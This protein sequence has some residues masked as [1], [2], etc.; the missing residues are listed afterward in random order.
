MNKNP[1]A[2][3]RIVK[4]FAL[5]ECRLLAESNRTFEDIYKI[6]FRN[7]QMVMAETSRGGEIL[8]C[9]YDDASEKIDRLAR[10]I[11][12]ATGETGRFVGISVKNCI[13]WIIIFWAILKSGNKPFLV[14][15]M[16]PV[17]ASN[18]VLTTLSADYVIYL[19]GNV[20]DYGKKPLLYSELLK[21]GESNIGDG[22]VPSFANEIAITTSGTSLNEKICIYSGAEITEQILNSK[23]AIGRDSDIARSCNGKIKIFAVLPLFHIFGLEATYLWLAFFRAVLV[24]PENMNPDTLLSTVRKHGIT[25]IFAVPL[26]WHTIEKTVMRELSKQDQKTQNEFEKGVKLSLAVQNIAPHLGKKLASKLFKDIRA[27][28]FGDS[29]RFCISGGSYIKESAL[30]LMNALGYSLINGYGMSEIG[31]AAANMERKPKDRMLTSIGKNFSSLQFDIRDGGKLFVK[32]DSVCKKIIINGTPAE[33]SEWFDTGD[34]AECDGQ[35]RYYIKGRASDVI[36]GDNG[37]NLN[38]DLAEREFEL[39]DACA[40]CVMGDETNENLMLVVQLPEGL[41]AEDFEALS[42]KISECE[43]KLPLSYRIKKIRYTK[44]PLSEAGDIKISRSKLK[45]DIANG[46]VQLFESFKEL[47]SSIYDNDSELK[48]EL[49]GIFASILNVSE[50]EITNTGHFMNDLGGSSLDYFSLIS[51]IDERFDI[52]LSFEGD[53]AAYSL[54]EFEKT[55]EG[56]IKK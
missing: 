49:R 8:T 47:D 40:F 51:A 22:A 32:G 41:S 31:I 14:N 20:T 12:K 19:D 13:E 53:E 4:R 2:N 37:E 35:G 15:L 54:N 55:V 43:K 6:V 9:T 29:V 42:K 52:T 30:K 27:R 36:I 25:H 24:F 50:S 45:R 28:L 23:E 33:Q 16:Q 56:L 21:L 48:K 38:P 34:I 1:H 18:S 10:G 7:P 17:N 5:N 11:S 46:S 39:T 3:S 26:L 44:A